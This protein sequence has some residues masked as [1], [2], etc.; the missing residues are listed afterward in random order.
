MQIQIIMFHEMD[1]LNRVNPGC[2]TSNK[3]NGIFVWIGGKTLITLVIPL[4]QYFINRFGKMSDT[5]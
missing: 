1:L 5:H 2:L 3:F 4:F